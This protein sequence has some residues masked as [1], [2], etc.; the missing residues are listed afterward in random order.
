MCIR[1]RS[2]GVF[3]MDVESQATDEGC[4]ACFLE[5]PLLVQLD[6]I[7]V[8]GQ[9]KAVCEIGITAGYAFCMLMFGPFMLLGAATG[10]CA[11]AE[12]GASAA[13]CRVCSAILTSVISL[14]ISIF[15][16]IPIAGGLIAFAMQQGLTSAGEV[17]PM[18]KLGCIII[19]VDFS[20][21][22][23]H[24]ADPG[25]VAGKVGRKAGME[26]WEHADMTNAH[27]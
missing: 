4:C 16:I 2:T 23:V 13:A 10:L 19:F 7:P 25:K 27:Y 22:P 9:I 18:G 24:P 14:I 8:I 12:G 26:Y 6:M 3:E 17:P 21:S 11:D 15:K 1:D 5:L 20:K